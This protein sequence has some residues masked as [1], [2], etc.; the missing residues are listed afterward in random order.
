MLPPQGSKA[1][2]EM[3]EWHKNK[4]ETD[5]KFRK[6]NED[7]MYKAWNTV[8]MINE[9]G[10]GL[11]Q[12][13]ELR[14]FLREF[15]ERNFEHG[16][17]SMPSSFNVVEGFFKY[18][19]YFELLEEEDNQFSL[20][21][22]ID[23]ITDSDFDREKTDLRELLEEDIIYSYN[24]TDNLDRYTFKYDEDTEFGFGGISMVKRGNE[25]TILAILGEKNRLKSGIK[26]N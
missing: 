12:D 6:I 1:L 22:Y 10:A 7:N 23:F 20:F 11:L 15:N 16:L 19:H 13:S 25:I 8:K 26:K 5:P 24:N 9:N 17:G 4:M 2:S 18:N 3:M 21:E 14:Y